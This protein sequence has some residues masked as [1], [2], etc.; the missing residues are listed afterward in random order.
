MSIECTYP[1]LLLYNRLRQ[2][3]ATASKDGNAHLERVLSQHSPIK[4]LKST[5]HHRVEPPHRRAPQSDP[6]RH[7]YGSS[8]VV[9]SHYAAKQ[10]ATVSSGEKQGLCQT[11][12]HKL[13][14]LSYEQRR[15]HE[16]RTFHPVAFRFELCEHHRHGCLICAALFNA[17][18]SRFYDLS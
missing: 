5:Y 17:L 11:K 16:L 2:R 13:S 4:R 14:S 3:Q 9:R 8:R 10:P 6:P 12:T 15:Q 1:T 18:V 7:P